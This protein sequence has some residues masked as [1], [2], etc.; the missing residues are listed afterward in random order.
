M[1][2]TA[3]KVAGGSVLF[4]ISRV[5]RFEKEFK[6]GGARLFWLFI[7]ENSISIVL[8]WSSAASLNYANL[9]HRVN[10][11]QSVNVRQPVAQL[12][13]N[14]QITLLR[15]QL[16]KRPSIQIGSQKSESGH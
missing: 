11:Q 14:I 10:F 6:V 9:N 4:C 16:V 8:G 15:C 13:G 12:G 1:R 5:G 7:R 2:Q 3:T